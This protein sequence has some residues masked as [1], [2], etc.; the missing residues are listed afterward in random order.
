[1]PS[2]ASSLC[3]CLTCPRPCPGPP[4]SALAPSSPQEQDPKDSEWRP[5]WDEHATAQGLRILT[6]TSCPDTQQRPGLSCP[7]PG[8][9]WRSQL[10]WERRCPGW[11]FRV[12]A[13][14]LG[15]PSPADWM[16]VSGEYFLP[17]AAASMATAG[18]SLCGFPFLPPFVLGAGVGST[19]AGGSWEPVGWLVV[20]ARVLPVVRS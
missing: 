5:S 3:P 16:R 18:E 11:P 14:P 2:P 7:L 20:S 9:P 15:A 8:C 10:T 19:P 4:P 13:N 12:Q 1:M 17:V 6:L